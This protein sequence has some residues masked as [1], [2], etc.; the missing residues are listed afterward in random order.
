MWFDRI[1]MKTLNI[2]KVAYTIDTIIGGEG[3]KIAFAKLIT[4]VSD[5]FQ[6]L[7]QVTTVSIS[8]DAK[9]IHCSSLYCLYQ[10]L[11]LPKL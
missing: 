6:L 8:V 3:N 11:V 7:T 9:L 10:S 4:E 1:K 2:M 5:N